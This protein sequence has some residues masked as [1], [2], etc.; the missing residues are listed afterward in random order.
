[1]G[2]PQAV[3]DFPAIS[4]DGNRSPKPG[5]TWTETVFDAPGPDWTRGPRSG[6]VEITALTGQGPPRLTAVFT[7]GD[8]DVVS[9]EGEVPGMGSW[10]GSGRVAYVAG[11]GTGKF[12]GRTGSLSVEFKNPKKWG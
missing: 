11:S 10:K 6:T 9:L 1:M 7:F 5:D 3:C 2:D 12:A 8:G 4:D